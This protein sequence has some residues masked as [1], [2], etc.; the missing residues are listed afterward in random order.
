MA[1]SIMSAKEARILQAY[2]TGR[3]VQIR[4]SPLYNLLTKD[5]TNYDLFMRYMA[6]TPVGD[7]KELKEK[8]LTL[9]HLFDRPESSSAAAAGIPSLPI[10]D[11]DTIHL[12][13]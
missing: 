7:T 1:I 4:Y 11:K 3:H 2:W 8:A 12:F 9:Q 6:N 5:M 13:R 10:P